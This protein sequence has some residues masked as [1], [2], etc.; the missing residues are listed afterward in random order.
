[1]AS[2]VKRTV[3]LAGA[4]A[5]IQQYAVEWRALLHADDARHAGQP[6]GGLPNRTSQIESRLRADSHSRRYLPDRALDL[7][8]DAD[9]AAAWIEGH[10]DGRPFDGWRGTPLLARIRWSRPHRL[11]S[12]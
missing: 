3:P 4:P 7:L 11:S 5:A 9:D 2:L 1:M 10:V 12:T 8:D 6:P